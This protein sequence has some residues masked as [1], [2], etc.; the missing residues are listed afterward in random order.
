L[1]K[2]YDLTDA[3]EERF[4]KA[5]FT[6]GALMSDPDILLRLAVEIGLPADK[7]KAVLASDDYTD[8]VQQDGRCARNLGATGVPFFLFNE[9]SAVNG[10]Q[11][12]ELLLQTLH[13][14]C[15]Q[16][17]VSQKSRGSSADGISCSPEGECD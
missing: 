4:F 15:N 1:S 2:A 12:P 14:A 3:I 11:S 10:A 9:N 7:V 6:E 16:L 8:A 17:N 5:Y 13:N